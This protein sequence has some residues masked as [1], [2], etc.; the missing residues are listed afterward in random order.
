MITV[1]IIACSENKQ[2]SEQGLLS[3]ETKEIRLGSS[4]FVLDLPESYELTEARGKEGQ[5]GYTIHPK[6]SLVTMSGF[7]E[8]KKGYPV[9]RPP[10]EAGREKNNISS[11][12]LEKQILWDVYETESGY[13]V[14]EIPDGAIS[15][16]VSSNKRNE[17]DSL[18]SI[19]ATLKRKDQEAK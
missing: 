16:T 14:A 11:T 4:E 12:F 7:I 9:N 6:D 13:F 5:L 3:G 19:I 2:V 10:L 1:S 18:I 15:A 8:I 17:V